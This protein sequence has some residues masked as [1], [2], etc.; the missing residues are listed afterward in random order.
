MFVRSGDLTKRPRLGEIES[1]E[2][3]RCYIPDVDW[4]KKVRPIGLT[5]E[6]IK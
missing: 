3:L 4:P 6:P 1:L 5:D 2:V